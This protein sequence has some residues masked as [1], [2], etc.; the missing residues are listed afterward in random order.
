MAAGDHAF[1]GLKLSEG[2]IW[3]S[4]LSGR[5]I[6]ILIVISLFVCFGM[7]II[8]LWGVSS[9]TPSVTSGSEWT[10][11]SYTDA[12]GILVPVITG[13]EITV[14]FG[15]DANITGNSGCNQYVAAYLVK[16]SLIAITYPISTKIACNK[17]GIMQQENA[18]IFDLSQVTSIQ[19]SAGEM[20]LSDK[21]NKIILIFRPE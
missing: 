15:R 1:A 13:S 2:M 9:G 6:T 14:R 10:L 20:K 17:P 12:T 7:I 16:G 5:N 4:L 21:N 18:Y 3:R 8:F 11:E 19:Q